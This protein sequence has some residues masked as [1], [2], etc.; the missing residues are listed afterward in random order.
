MSLR[1]RTF[2]WTITA[3]VVTLVVGRIAV[4]PASGNKLPWALS[5]EDALRRSAQSGK[6][7]MVVFSSRGCTWCRKLQT[8]TF[9]D[10]RVETAAKQVIPVLVST[11][12]R[13]DLAAEYNVTTVPLTVFVDGK[14][15]RLDSVGGYV[16]ADI[17]AKILVEVSA[18]AK[19][20]E[21]VPGSPRRSIW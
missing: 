8:E 21:P 1:A 9:A 18:A 19:R 15:N 12:E 17:F 7:A 6:P 16:D 11:D 2:G 14:A 10:A 20:G 13:P 3:I 4:D 5:Y